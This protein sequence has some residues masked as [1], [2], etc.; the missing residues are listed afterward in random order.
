MFAALGIYTYRRRKWIVAASVVVFLLAV[1][2]GSGAIDRLKPGGFED[3]NSESFIA[4][5]L[6]QA[7]LGQGQSNLFVV[8]SSDELA[9]ENP[10]FQRA[11]EEALA[12]LAKD[13]AVARIDT[14]YTTR[15]PSFVAQDGTK[16]FALLGLTQDVDSASEDF[17]RLRSMLS[18]QVLEINVT[19]QPAADRQI[20]D[21]CGVY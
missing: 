21:G 19:G 7:Q 16:T 5:E 6:L 12:P 4:K 10:R 18:S 3:E 15:S 11:V 2:F 1:V 14:F 17:P 13:S 20:Q 8:F 9:V